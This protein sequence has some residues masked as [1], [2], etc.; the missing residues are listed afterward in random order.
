MRSPDPT[1]TRIATALTQWVSRT[2][3]WF[4]LTFT[5]EC[6]RSGTSDQGSANTTSALPRLSPYNSGAN[7]FIHPPQPLGTATYCLPLT[8]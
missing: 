7:P 5:A 8:L 2:S 4:R 6:A 1:M 3:Q